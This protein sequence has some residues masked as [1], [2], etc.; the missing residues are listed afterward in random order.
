MK[1]LLNKD[2]KG[3][4]KA[5]EVKEVK[6][7]Y[8]VNF[9]FPKGLAKDASASTL[10][11]HQAELKRAEDKRRY[12][13]EQLEKLA[14][15]LKKVV[16]SFKKPVGENGALFGSVTKDEVSKALKEQKGLELDKKCIEDFHTKTVGLYEVQAKL[17]ESVVAVFKIDVKAE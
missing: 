14:A 8:A 15:E 12:E 13:H 3:L 17:G 1:V 2:I 11:Q 5:G 10:R 9:L 7:G 16:L 6:D 4:G